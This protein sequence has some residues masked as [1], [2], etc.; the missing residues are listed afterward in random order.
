MRYVEKL[1]KYR[2]LRESDEESNALYT[3]RFFRQVR[4][5]LPPH[6]RSFTCA[7]S[8]SSEDDGFSRGFGRGALRLIGRVRVLGARVRALRIFTADLRYTR[9]DR[10]SRFFPIDSRQVLIPR[11][12]SH[13]GVRVRRVRARVPSN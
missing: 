13:P 2:S 11:T 6:R 12:R 5:L 4:Q 9:G 3:R 8:V 1:N 10:E 7:G